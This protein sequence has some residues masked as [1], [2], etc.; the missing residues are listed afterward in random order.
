LDET[1]GETHTRKVLV[2]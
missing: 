1:K 2:R